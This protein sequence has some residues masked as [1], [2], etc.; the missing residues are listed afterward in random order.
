MVAAGI[1]QPPQTSPHHMVAS[2]SPKAAPAR[3]QLANFGIDIND[4][5]NG[6]FLPR[7]SA[8]PNPTGAAV[9]SKVHAN[10]YYDTVNYLM[11]GA[12]N[13][14]EGTDVL[15]YI[16]NQLQAGPWP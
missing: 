13:A 8:S 9:H 10:V 16:R 15:N 6:V 12:R 1:P 11:S 3:Q 7:G 4:P 2:T 5:R 14:S